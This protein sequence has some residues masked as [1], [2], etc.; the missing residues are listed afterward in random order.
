MSAVIAEWQRPDLAHWLDIRHVGAWV[1]LLA[2]LAAPRRLRL[3]DALVVLAF[4][5]LALSAKRHTALAMIAVAPIA[6]GAVQRALGEMG[7]HG[8]YGDECKRSMD[9]PNL[10]A[11]GGRPGLRRADDRRPGRLRPEARGH[12]H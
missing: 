1:F 9:L 10:A 7:E 3:T 5:A 8:K 2:I 6:A 4:G 11:G 12:R